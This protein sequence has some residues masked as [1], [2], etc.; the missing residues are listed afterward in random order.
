MRKDLKI[1]L[2][3]L[4][5]FVMGGLTSCSLEGDPSMSNSNSML[6]KAPKVVAYSGDHYWNNGTRSTD[7]NA[8]MWNQN[9]DC[10]P[11]PAED[12]SEDELAELKALLSKGSETHNTVVLPFENY[13][14]QQIYKGEDT[15]HTTDRCAR[16][17]YDGSGEIKC[18]GNNYCDHLKEGDHTNSNSSVKGSDHMDKLGAYNGYGYEHINNFNNGT[19]NDYPGECG[20]GERHYKTTLM[21]NMPTDGIDPE[22]QFYFHET[23]GTQHDYYNYIIVEYK[24]YWYVG[25][26]FESHKPDQGTHNHDEGMDIERDWNFTDWIVRITPAYHVGQT[27]E[28]NP[29]GVPSTDPTQPKEECD[30][31]G[32][33]SHDPGNCDECDED[34]GCNHQD[35]PDQPEKPEI[36]PEVQDHV[37]V[38]LSIE[39]HNYTQTDSHLS[40][41]VRSATDVE[42]FIPVPAKYYCEADD[43]AIVEKHFE[44]M[45][46]HGGPDRVEYNVGGNIVTLNIEFEEGGIRIWTEGINEAV[47]EYCREKYD[48]GITFEVWNYFNEGITKEALRDDY[49]NH[50]TVKFLDKL[51]DAY[52]NAFNDLWDDPETKFEWDCTVSIVD[53]QRGDYNDPEEGLHY[54]GSKFNEIYKNKNA[55][56]GSSGEE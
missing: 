15:Y 47:I 26:D 50:S 51:P 7:M 44:E 27:P 55:G 3:A 43:M 11:R 5:A 52:V 37:E 16:E 24:G 32:H 28:D 25:F 17:A 4:G 45:M 38:N 10:P 14:V 40:I 23:W 42:V 1:T 30:K 18:G 8:N 13:Y 35:T 41:H 2:F 46:I 48:D 56:N 21:T 29:G 39:D 36:A 19:N 6:V 31:C 9:W 34:E 49:L 12:L 22:E 33:P 54:N 53:N 20:C